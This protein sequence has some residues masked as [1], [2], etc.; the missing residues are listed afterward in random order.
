[1][2]RFHQEFDIFIQALEPVR[3]EDYVGLHRSRSLGRVGGLSI[4]SQ[5]SSAVIK[6]GGL[7]ILSRI[8][9]PSVFGLI[10][11]VG[12][13]DQLL[14]TVSA[15]GLME[16][17]VQ[18]KSLSR[19]DF[20]G[21]FWLNAIVSTLLAGIFAS[22]APFLT[23]FYGE[24]EL[25]WLT[26]ALAVQFLIRGIVQPRQAILSRCM[27]GEIQFVCTM[28]AQII[29]VVA[30]I[31][32]AVKGHG[33][34]SIVYGNFIGLFFKQIALTYFVRVS[35]FASFQWKGLLPYIKYGYRATFGSLVGFISLNV[36]TLALGKYASASD[37]GFYNRAQGLYQQPIRQLAWPLI[38]VTLPAMSKRQDD[39]VSLLNLVTKTTWI[40]SILLIPIAL[41]FIVF[42]DTAVHYLLGPEWTITGE[43]I[44]YVAIAQIPMIF[45]TPLTRANAAIGRP[46][47]AAPMNLILLPFL[48][49]GVIHY[50]P[51]GAVAVA[52]FIAVFR[53]SFYLPFLFITFRGSG[54]DWKK[55][56][57]ALSPLQAYLIVAASGGLLARKWIISPTQETF[58]YELLLMGGYMV[59]VIS[60]LAIIYLNHQ[61]GKEV[62]FWFKC[63]L[64]NKA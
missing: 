6:I 11:I 18:S 29:G 25:F 1:M 38:G 56:L 60:G 49:L 32:F 4:V 44:R 52:K 64:L 10:A 62:V 54:L 46:A 3:E 53:L 35:Y 9:P 57:W 15:A 40:I 31:W 45:S 27:R 12:F 8:L 37:V 36:Q 19:T 14:Q 50:A 17:L 26:I 61:T 30:T 58:P 24:T 28:G 22:L 43:V 34:W 2:S 7:V 33:V 42:G 59:L 39:R 5:G 55:Y 47:R 16:S 21:V 63:K 20:A 41:L 23:D 13:F 48:C 51:S